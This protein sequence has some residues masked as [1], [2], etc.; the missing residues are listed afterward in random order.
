MTKT[1]NTKANIQMIYGRMARYAAMAQYHM[2]NIEENIAPPSDSSIIT[3]NVD[4]ANQ[5][6]LEGLL[7]DFRLFSSIEYLFS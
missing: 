5:I 4:N 6:I 7:G 3:F 1:Q 2:V